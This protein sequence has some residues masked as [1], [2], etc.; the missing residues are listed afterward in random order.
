MLGF[1]VVVWNVHGFRAGV[2]RVADAVREM[3]PDIL[4]LNEA[5]FRWRVRGL[6]RRLRMGAHHGLGRPAGVQ[7]AVL[8]RPPWRIVEGWAAPLSPWPGL[9]RRGVV[10]ARVGRSGTRLTVAGVHLGVAD[11]ERVRHAREVTD[12]LAGAPGPLL[13]GGDLNESPDAPATEWIAGR[14]LDAFAARGVGG[15]E[16]FPSRRPRARIDYLFVTGDVEIRAV[17]VE[18]GPAVIQASDH[19]PVVADLAVDG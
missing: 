12:M 4:I 8:A 11:A 1:R 6:A 7:N 3:G 14:Y 9:K 15:G 10:A 2:G 13:L 16:T 18:D 19:R 5:R 17:R